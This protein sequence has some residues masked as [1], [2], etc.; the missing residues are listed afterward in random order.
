MADR[1]IWI[2]DPFDP[3]FE[4]RTA[5][6]LRPHLPAHPVPRPLT[7]A[8]PS[9]GRLWPSLQGRFAKGYL[10][11]HRAGD[12]GW[13]GLATRR[14]LESIVEEAFEAAPDDPDLPVLRSLMGGLDPRTIYY[15]V[16][17][18]DLPHDPRLAG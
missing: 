7:P 10:A 17:G 9:P 3:H 1:T 18:P 11:A 13:I 2:G 14:E 8:L 5:H 12:D 4:W 15:V 6:P 16:A